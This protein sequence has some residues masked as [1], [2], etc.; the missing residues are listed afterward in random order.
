MS[1]K[2]QVTKE[3]A[4]IPAGR[5]TADKKVWRHESPMRSVVCE[6]RAGESEQKGY[7]ADTWVGMRCVG[8]YATLKD[9]DLRCL[10]GSV[11]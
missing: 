6:Y 2:V 9:P 11:G 10:G 7:E 8:M 5:G 4:G 3:K 1:W